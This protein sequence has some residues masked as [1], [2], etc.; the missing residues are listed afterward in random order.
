[1]PAFR[2]KSANRIHLADFATESDRRAAPANLAA[3][4]GIDPSDF[5]TKIDNEYFPL[6]PGT[7][8]IYDGDSAEGHEH[9]EFTVT[10]NT[11][12]IMGVKCVEILDTLYVD[13]ELKERTLDWFAQDDDGNVWYFGEDT[14]EYENGQVVSTEG[15]WKAGVDGALPGIIMEADPK[16]GDQY[17]QELAPGVAEDKAQVISD[18]VRK[19]VAYG[20]FGEVLKTK[21]FTPLEPGK[22]EFKY[23]AEGIGQILTESTQTGK[24]LELTAIRFDGTSA[25]ET[26]NGQ[27]GADLLYGNGG[28]DKLKGEGG[29]DQLFGGNGRDT[30]NGGRGDDSSTGGAGADTFVFTDLRNG[31]VEHDTILDYSRAQGDRI[32]LPNGAGSVA[33][34]FFASGVWHL[35]LK[36]DGDLLDVR[37][38]V[39]ANH[40]SHI[41]DD[42]AII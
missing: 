18:E 24:L 38:A 14:K 34:E 26:I 15:S 13:G 37:G 4:N 2:H 41:L 1:M 27:K 33:R 21:E 5:T 40:N 32:D 25:G 19:S 8:L 12:T 10:R 20:A 31:K 30:L 29:D 35:K 23:Y 17:N 42:L 28:N 6:T 3:D 36:G 11:V 7:T 39:D 16:R 9:D 22:F